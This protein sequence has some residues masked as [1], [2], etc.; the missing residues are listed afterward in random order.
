MRVCVAAINGAFDTGFTS[1]LDTLQMAADL[2]EAAG[3][4]RP[5]EVSVIGVRRRV[6][7]QLGMRVPALPPPRNRPDVVVVPALGAK[8]PETLGVALEAREAL[9][10]G[11]LLSEW[12]RAGTL[13]AAACTATFLVARAG[14]LDDREATTSW[15]LG[16]YFRECFPRVRLDESR[17]VVHAKGCL[18][19][20]AALAHVDLALWLIRRHSPTLARTTANFLTYEDRASQAAF[21]MHDHLPPSDDIVDRFEDWAR[22]HLADFSLRGAAR[23]VGTSER[24]LE[25]RLSLALG[26]SPKAFVQDLRVERAVHRLRSSQNSL[27]EIASEVGYSDAVTLRT[28]LRRRTGRGIREL[29]R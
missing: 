21:V 1:V 23:A 11:A 12:S 19:A 20:G 27:D 9:D 13:V 22:K 14:L 7:T 28:L 2:A 26:K 15:W 8:S 16:R 17:I 24:T 29:R 4:E 10:F 6:T 25:R 5:F 3:R 18:T